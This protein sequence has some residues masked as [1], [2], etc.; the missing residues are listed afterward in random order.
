MEYPLQFDG[1][2]S[3]GFEIG[4][5][6]LRHPPIDAIKLVKLRESMIQDGW[7]GRPVILIDCGDDHLALTGTHRFCAAVGLPMEIEA[8][9]YE[10]GDVGEEFFKDLRNACEDEEILQILIK[11]ELDEAIEIMREEVFQN[12]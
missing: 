3:E 11:H 8:L 7:I 5:V 6:R 10:A 1:R 2:T 9:I 12:G 4:F